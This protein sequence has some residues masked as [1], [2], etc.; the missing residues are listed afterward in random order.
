MSTYTQILYQVVFGSKD[1]TPFLT[2]ENEN[3]LFAYIAGILKNKQCHSYIVGGVCNHIHIITHLHPVV[4][5]S[6][7]IKDIKMASHKMILENNS[8]F[9]NFTGWQAGYSAFTYNISSKANLINYVETQKEHHKIKSFKD[10]LTSLLKEHSVDYIDDYL[11][12]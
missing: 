10:E 3:M 8:L 1:Y 5:L 6:G 9:S 4:P 2:S 7:L 12:I 11:L